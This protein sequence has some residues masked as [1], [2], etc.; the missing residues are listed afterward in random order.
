MPEIAATSDPVQRVRV[1]DVPVRLFHWTLVG[2][3]VTLFVTAEVLEDAIQTH[4]L[5]GYAVLALVLFRILWGFLGNSR[6]RFA[7]FVRGPGEVLRYAAG[8]F[9]GRHEFHAGHNPLGGWMVLALL[10]MV[11]LQAG[12]GLFTNDDIL[13]EGPL[14][15]WVS[16][17]TSDWLTG[18]H[19]DVFHVL[20]VM[21]ALHVSAVVLHRFLHGE[22]LVV[23]MFTGCKEVPA[24]ESA[25]DATGGNPLLAVLLLAVCAGAVWLLVA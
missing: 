4:A 20:L 18:L 1:W 25:G 5:A 10:A 15:H 2:L 22:N 16:K 17:D 13:F 21:V 3:M 12:I 19:E 11:L 14:A 7:D 6:A 23:A 9:R 24:G 8:F